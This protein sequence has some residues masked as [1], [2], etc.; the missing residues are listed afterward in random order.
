[1]PFYSLNQVFL[2][3]WDMTSSVSNRITE[4]EGE[5]E[6]LMDKV[7]DLNRAMSNLEADRSQ[8]LLDIELLDNS[9]YTKVATI[10]KREKTSVNG[11]TTNETKQ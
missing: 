9:F 8:L 6:A 11:K 2:Y 3:G 1:M 4:L 10:R 5:L 7:A